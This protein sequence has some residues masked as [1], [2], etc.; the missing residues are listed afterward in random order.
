MNTGTVV[1]VIGP[2]IDVRFPDEIPA[3][4]NALT[5]DGRDLVREADVDDRPDDLDDCAYVHCLNSALRMWCAAAAWTRSPEGLGAGHDLED[6]LRDGR[7]T[8]A[9]ERQRERLEHLLGAVAGVAHGRHPRSLLARARLEQGAVDGDLHVGRQQALEDDVGFGL[10]QLG[11]GPGVPGLVGDRLARH[12]EDDVVEERLLDRR[13]EVVVDEPHSVDLAAHIQVD[14]VLGDLLGVAVLGPVAQA[15]PA[16]LEAAPAEGH[17]ADA[18]AAHGDEPR[19]DAPAAE[20]ALDLHGLAHHVALKAPA[21][22]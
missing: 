17:S 22:P 20:P 14:E 4:Y 11:H 9:V 8:G 10:E 2:V 13:R 18:L 16:A 6:L 3:I 12:R 7:L 21:R 5:V 15:L 19:L 1:Q